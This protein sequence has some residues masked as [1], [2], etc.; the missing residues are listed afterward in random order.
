[1]A[2]VVTRRGGRFEIRESIHTDRGPRA[3]SLANFAVLTEAVIEQARRRAWR[4]FDPA[5]VRAAALRAGVP[6]AGTEGAEGGAGRRPARPGGGP[7]RYRSFVAA[8]RRLARDWDAPAG[9]ERNDPGSDLVALLG[10]ADEVARHQPPREPE[11]LRF[12]PLATL[13]GSRSGTGPARSG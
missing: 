11:P 4:R 3:R 6:V 7:D 12:P 10:F 9:R 5:A 8:S 1:M 13:A 2:Y